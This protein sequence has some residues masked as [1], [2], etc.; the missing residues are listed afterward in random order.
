MTRADFN[1]ER[2]RRRLGCLKGILSA[3]DVALRGMFRWSVLSLSAQE[4]FLVTLVVNTELWSTKN[5]GSVS[6]VC[7]RHSKKCERI[8]EIYKSYKQIDRLIDG[9]MDRQTHVLG[10][11]H[12]HYTN[13]WKLGRGVAAAGQSSK[14]A[15][16][17]AINQRINQ[18]INQSSNQAIK[19]ASKQ[20]SKEASKQASSQAINQAIYQ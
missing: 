19:Q 4:F 13:T 6:G 1:I 18:S 7:W 3:P 10:Y 16:N 14:Q 11:F 17:Q 2:G 15:S 12:I 8:C 20:A 5:E 9:W